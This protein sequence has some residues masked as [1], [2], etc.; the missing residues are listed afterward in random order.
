M[1]AIWTLTQTDAQAC[2][3][4][5]LHPVGALDIFMFLHLHCSKTTTGSLWCTGV[6]TIAEAVVT[7]VRFLRVTAQLVLG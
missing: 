2:S 6:V 1:F 7:A 4:V 5:I 3:L